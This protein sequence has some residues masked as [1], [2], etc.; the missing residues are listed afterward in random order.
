M[1][2]TSEETFRATLQ[3]CT[4]E[5]DSATL[6]VTRRGLGRSGRVWL[7]F[8]GSIRATLVMTDQQ[9]VRLLDLLAAAAQRDR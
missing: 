3:G 6:I 1:S 7:T 2:T 5:S 8:N 4:P 9:A